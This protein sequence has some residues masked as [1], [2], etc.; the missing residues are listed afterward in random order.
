MHSVINTEARNPIVLSINIKKTCRHLA[1]FTDPAGLIL[2]TKG[3][4]SAECGCNGESGLLKL[5]Q[6]KPHYLSL[7]QSLNSLQITAWKIHLM[8][9]ECLFCL[10][11]FFMFSL[12]IIS[13]RGFC[14]RGQTFSFWPSVLLLI[15]LWLLEKWC[16]FLF[17]WRIMWIMTLPVSPDAPRFNSSQ[18][19]HIVL[20]F[21][22]INRFSMNSNIQLSGR[23]A[24]TGCHC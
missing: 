17:F 8:C 3:K 9:P 11:F 10:V 5:L 14:L 16:K 22:A 1:C 20:R 24:W 2:H 21:G 23:Q 7:L 4:Q 6:F 12:T 15:S 18:R 19:I 13:Q